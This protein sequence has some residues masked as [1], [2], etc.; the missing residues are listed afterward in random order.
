M[1]MANPILDALRSNR[2]LPTP[3]W[4]PRC[5]L[6]K[7]FRSHPEH[8]DWLTSALLEGTLTQTEIAA[9]IS[10]RTG[11]RVEQSQVSNHKTRHLDPTLRDAYETFLGRTVMLQALG[12][13]PPAEMA[14]A[15][16]QLAL[17]ELSKRLPE[18]T[19]KAAP[20]MAAGIAALSR[21]VQSGVKLPREIAALDLANAALEAQRAQA[22]GRYQEA[23][24]QYVERHYP[25]LAG[26]L[27]GAPDA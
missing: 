4:Q 2:L 3:H 23:F 8:Y 22:E 27:A 5:D 15:Y 10:R 7:L 12:D 14:V 18:A 9:E 13:M 11:L 17:L 25:E 19:D 16:A 6:C 26:H 1:A 20:A 21:A 24:V